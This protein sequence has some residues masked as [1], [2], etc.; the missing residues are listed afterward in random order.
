MAEQ[1]VLASRLDVEQRPQQPAAVVHRGPATEGVRRRRGADGDV[2]GMHAGQEDAGLERAVDRVTPV[3]RPAGLLERLAQQ[4]DDGAEVG[5][6]LGQFGQAD[7]V[8]VEVATAGGP[9][10]AGRG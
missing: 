1:R 8:L 5:V 4:S 9:T 3:D 6:G 7:R 10:L 2:A